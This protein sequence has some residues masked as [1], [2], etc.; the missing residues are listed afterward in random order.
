M[1][2]S[3]F[4]F[5]SF[6]RIVSIEYTNDG[7]CVIGVQVADSRVSR[8]FKLSQH[9]CQIGWLKNFHKPDLETLWELTKQHPSVSFLR[10]VIAFSLI[11]GLMLRDMLIDWE[12]EAKRYIP[13]VGRDFDDW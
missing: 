5:H 4:G 7:F 9:C 11:K 13:G 12:E 3:E 2:Q 10:R 8:T 6:Y 1:N